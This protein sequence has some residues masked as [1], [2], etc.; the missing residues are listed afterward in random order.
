MT[1]LTFRRW[2]STFQEKSVNRKLP[3]NLIR[4]CSRTKKLFTPYTLITSDPIQ[5]II[6]SR[7]S[8]LSPCLFALSI[9]Q[10]FALYS[11]KT[12][13]LIESKKDL[14]CDLVAS[15]TVQVGDLDQCVHLWRYT[16]GFDKID[17]A[18]KDLK[19]DPVRNSDKKI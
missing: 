8:K 11:K 6:T 15:W 18:E 14:G 2:I 9:L 5:L 13:Q 12:V 4:V 3:R 7:T 1:L 17:L 16:G 10:H 19:L